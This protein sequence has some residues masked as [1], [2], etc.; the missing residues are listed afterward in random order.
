ML[1]AI[2][3]AAAAIGGPTTEPEAGVAISYGDACDER[4]WRLY[5]RNNHSHRSYL[6]TL[7]WSAAGGKALTRE[8]HIEPKVIQEVGC[9]EQ[10]AEIVKVV[11]ADF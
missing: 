11:L 3:N 2:V 1:L 6:V 9:A 5:V 4:N 10:N 8:L 7:R